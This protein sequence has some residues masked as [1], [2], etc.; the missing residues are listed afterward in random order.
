MLKLYNMVDIIMLFFMKNPC[1]TQIVLIWLCTAMSQI[2]NHFNHDNIK[3][4]KILEWLI[5]L[6]I[7]KHRL[8]VYLHIDF[9][10]KYLPN[11]DNLLSFITLFEE[12][13]ISVKSLASEVMCPNQ[14]VSN[15]GRA[16]ISLHVGFLAAVIVY[17]S[18]CFTAE[19]AREQLIALT[20]QRFACN[21]KIMTQYLHAFQTN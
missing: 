10:D 13:S 18:R 12:I 4:H 3:R 20:N 7:N 2:D 8:Y 19:L 6:I 15:N 16:R 1:I 5:H 17:Y 11:D 9:N 14:C 21:D